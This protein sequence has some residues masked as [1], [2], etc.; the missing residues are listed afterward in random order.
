MNKYLVLI[1]IIITS[2]SGC[3]DTSS[4]KSLELFSYVNDTLKID[5]QTRLILHKDDEILTFK[6]GKEKL[7]L[8]EVEIFI[9][10]EA[11]IIDSKIIIDPEEISLKQSKD[12][13][14]SVSGY[15]ISGSLLLVPK[16]ITDSLS[17]FLEI[18]A[19]SMIKKDGFNILFLD[20][21]YNSSKDRLFISNIIVGKNKNSSS[22]KKHKKEVT[23]ITGVIILLFAIL[24]WGNMDRITRYLK[25]RSAI[26]DYKRSGGRNKIVIA[27]LNY[28]KINKQELIYVS[29][30]CD[31]KLAPEHFV[32]EDGVKIYTPYE[33]FTA[34][35]VINLEGYIVS[36]LNNSFSKIISNDVF[37][38]ITGSQNRNGVFFDVRY[39]VGHTN[40]L[41]A[42]V[43]DEMKEGFMGIYI[44]WTIDIL[45][46]N[47][48]VHNF[49]LL[50]QPADSFKASQGLES[51]FTQ[52]SITAF[53]EFNEKLQMK[54]K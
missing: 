43:G 13:Q 48:P 27:V 35:K 46:K 26:N 12:K 14:E 47:K 28:L 3:R 53:H 42:R 40:G 2:I 52:M 5:W 51:V 45:I 29:F 38:F 6:K 19:V 17:I 50:T 24:A 25:L 8:D 20:R 41:Y 11:N 18:P 33:F 36:E 54:L 1:A 44:E 37:R 32:N 9:T 22:L 49:R 7:L 15:I 39:T 31:N 16:S 30:I 21:P 23:T 4:D 10:S 34:K